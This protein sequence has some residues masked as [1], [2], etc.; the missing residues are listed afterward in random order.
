MGSVM[1]VGVFRGV[2]SG[3]K[4]GFFLDEGTGLESATTPVIP[5]TPSANT[6]PLSEFY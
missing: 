2:V 3:P 1:T 5:Y 6:V 4:A